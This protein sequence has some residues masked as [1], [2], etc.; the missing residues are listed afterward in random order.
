[1]YKYFNENFK[2]I[3]LIQILIKFYNNTKSTYLS[4]L[5]LQ[6]NKKI[7]KLKKH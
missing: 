5:K 7:Q 4:F 6:L 1:M 2:G 3:K